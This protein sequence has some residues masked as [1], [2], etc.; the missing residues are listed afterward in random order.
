MHALVRRRTV[1]LAVLAATALASCGGG[2]GGDNATTP[3]P[4]ISAPSALSY[5][6]PQ[7]LTVGTAVDLAPTVSGAPTSYSVQPALPPGLALNTTSGRISGTPTAP[8]ALASH[9]VTATNSG[10]S[11]TFS[12]SLRVFEA[13]A[14][15]DR[16]DEA[17]GYQV[18]LMYVLPSDGAD[19][20]LAAALGKISP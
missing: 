12:L 16:A 4:T 10:G 5:P 13:R 18:H 11:T 14:T 19:E 9:V 8:R 2:G 6:S 3:P 20:Q 15:V 1:A 17:A 7:T